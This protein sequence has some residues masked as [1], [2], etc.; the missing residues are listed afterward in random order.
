MYSLSETVRFFA[1]K[2]QTGP[3]PPGEFDGRRP[4]CLS[5]TLQHQRGFTLVP[6]HPFRKGLELFT[7]TYQ[8]AFSQG[9]FCFAFQELKKKKWR[10][11]KFTD[12]NGLFDLVL[13]FSIFWCKINKTQRPAKRPGSAQAGWRL[14]LIGKHPECI[15]W[16]WH[17]L[18]NSPPAS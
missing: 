8:K 3:H 11:L 17:C 16:W 10:N 12:K 9:F 18:F 2:V 7:A 13:P 5:S 4:L 1:S 14:Y 6:P 15:S